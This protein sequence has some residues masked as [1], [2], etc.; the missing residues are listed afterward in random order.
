VS[1]VPPKCDGADTSQAFCAVPNVRCPA[2]TK[3][4][5]TCS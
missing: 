2:G 1:G 4:V 5:D 3:K